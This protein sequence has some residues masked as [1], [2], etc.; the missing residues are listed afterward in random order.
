MTRYFWGRNNLQSALS[1][2]VTTRN[3]GSRSNVVTVVK[4]IYQYHGGF[5]KANLSSLTENLTAS[6]SPTFSPSTYNYSLAATNAEDEV[7]LTATLSGA[8]IL[9]SYGE[10]VDKQVASG[11]GETI[12]L[13][14]GAN[15][16]TIKVSKPSYD[17]VIY[18]IT[19]TRAAS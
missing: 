16:I 19:V 17:T 5:R 9:Y 13:N 8:T 4:G 15:V 11:V 3:T 14:V 12:P 7:K 18:T 2:L 10:V 6:F 1:E